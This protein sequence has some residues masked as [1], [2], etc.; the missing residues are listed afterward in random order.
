MNRINDLKDS[1]K[2]DE[3]TQTNDINLTGNL[4]KYDK[5]L[6][7]TIL[8]EDDHNEHKIKNPEM[9]VTEEDE[10]YKTY[11]QKYQKEEEEE[12]EEKRQEEEH[13]TI[14]A[15][16]KK[17]ERIN[18]KI[19]SEKIQKKLNENVLGKPKEVPNPE[20]L[21]KEGIKK[22][23]SDLNTENNNFPSSTL[24]NA[25]K[26]RKKMKTHKKRKCPNKKTLNKRK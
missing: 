22:R 16:I 3:I 21:L 19:I 4:N 9:Y 18:E 2:L 11:L 10:E 25:G 5:N 1:E 15:D 8:T 12:E 17:E 14:D 26:R 7:P 13:Q 24:Q 20:E 23:I 6:I